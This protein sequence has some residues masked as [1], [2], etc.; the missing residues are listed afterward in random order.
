MIVGCPAPSARGA[1][2]FEVPHPQALGAHDVDERHPTE[3]QQKTQER[4]EARL[5][6]ARQDDK[7]E[8]NRQ[9]R[10]DLDE[11]LEREVCEATE[12]TLHGARDDANHRA[13][14]RQRQ[15]EEDRYAK[16]VDETGEHVTALIVG[17][18]PV[19]ARGRRRRRDIEIVVDRAVAVG[20]DGPDRPAL[21]F[22]QLGYSKTIGL[23]FAMNS[24]NRVTKNRTRN[25]Q[26]ET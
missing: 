6:D 13:S 8:E 14:E 15:A 18:E 16:A 9:T 25:S 24:A 19:R 4:P 12:I 7:Q 1:D 26:S 3:Q 17:A 10:P 5:D 2:I 23:S 20:D 11:T 21:R 22:D